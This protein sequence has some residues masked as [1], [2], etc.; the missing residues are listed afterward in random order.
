L[1]VALG[2]EFEFKFVRIGFEKE[3]R[4]GNINKKEKKKHPSG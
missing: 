2:F 4:K 1:I 3:N